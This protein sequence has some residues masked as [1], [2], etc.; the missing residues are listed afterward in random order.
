MWD[1][2]TLYVH[3]GGYQVA[4]PTRRLEINALKTLQHPIA[5]VTKSVEILN[6]NDKFCNVDFVVAWRASSYS[7]VVTF[8]NYV[9]L[10]FYT[11][12]N[13]LEFSF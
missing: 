6:I 3:G 8:N 4:Q 2:Y 11:I 7:S 13:T 1:V 10:C 12:T 9:L 5:H